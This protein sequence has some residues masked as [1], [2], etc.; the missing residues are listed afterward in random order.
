M[1]TPRG[2]FLLDL[3]EELVRRDAEREQEPRTEWRTSV[4]G[5]WTRARLDVLSAE[6]FRNAIPASVGV[7]MAAPDRADPDVWQEDL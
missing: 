2:E 7:D 4:P 6:V 1:P 3:A 5:R